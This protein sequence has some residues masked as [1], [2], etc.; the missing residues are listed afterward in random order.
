MRGARRSQRDLFEPERA[1][2]ELR[3]DLRTNLTL[4]LRLLLTEA[5]GVVGQPASSGD[6]D[7]E[8]EEDEQDHA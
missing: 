1:V 7:D 6:R 3:P 8:G 4:L 5:A 2:P